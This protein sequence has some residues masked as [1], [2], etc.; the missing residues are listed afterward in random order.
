MLSL[1]P[2]EWY[3]LATCEYCHTRHVVELDPSKGGTL[4]EN[5]Y[6][7]TCPNCRRTGFYVSD[8]LERYQHPMGTTDAKIVT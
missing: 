4:A 6:Q 1:I 8:A 3:L 5:I 7:S 2:G